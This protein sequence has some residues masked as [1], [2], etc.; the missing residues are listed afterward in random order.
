[1]HHSRASLAQFVFVFPQQ[2]WRSLLSIA[3]AYTQIRDVVLQLVFPFLGTFAST[4]QEVIPRD[5]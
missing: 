2:L 3:D 5:A 4:A 1:L